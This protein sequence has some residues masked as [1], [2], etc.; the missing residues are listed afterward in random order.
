MQSRKKEMVPSG[1]SIQPHAKVP[2]SNGVSRSFAS[3]TSNTIYYSKEGGRE[4]KV[5]GKGGEEGRV[6]HLWSRG[7]R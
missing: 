5:E 2:T 4:G 1:G 6:T 3:G 7:G